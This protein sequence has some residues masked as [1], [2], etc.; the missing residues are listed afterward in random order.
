[1]AKTQSPGA[2]KGLRVSVH[3]LFLL[4]GI[5]TA[6]TGELFAFL[7]A[8]LAALEHEC[9]HAF[10]ARRMGYSLK[11]V[12]LMPYGAVI[13][14][15]VA[16]IA[17]KQEVA[18]CVAGPLCNAVTALFFVA[19]WWLFPETYP[20]TD[21]AAQVSFSLFLVNL[22]PAYPLD[23]GRVLRVLLRPLGERKAK[24]ITLTVTF[25]VAAGLLGLFV[26]SCFFQANVTILV[27]AVFLMAGCF[28]KE[29]YSRISFS[30]HKSLLRGVEERRVAIDATNT[31]GYCLRFLREDKYTVFVLFSSDSFFGELTEEEYLRAVEEGDWSQPIANLVNKF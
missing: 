31:V 7:A 11:R 27:F 14:G 5:I 30:R 29:G 19:L 15:D 10:V 2:K 28:G 20:Y 12:V 1:M 23:G 25:A 26:Y 8:T 24:I 16:G 18:V 13:S 6:I 4:V 17:P 22:L 9:A 3:P 21:T